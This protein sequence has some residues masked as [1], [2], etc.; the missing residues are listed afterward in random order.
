LAPAGLT[1][2]NLTPANLTP[3]RL[4]GEQHRNLALASLG[5]LLEF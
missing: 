5:S 1:P 2:A 4:T 3:A